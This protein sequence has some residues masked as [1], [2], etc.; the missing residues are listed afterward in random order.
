MSSQFSPTLLR[1]LRSTVVEVERALRL[2]KGDPGLRDLKQ[3]IVL[4]LGELELKRAQPRMRILWI[5]PPDARDDG[6]SRSAPGE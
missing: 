1:I 5:R 2:S 6:D 4:A 3:A